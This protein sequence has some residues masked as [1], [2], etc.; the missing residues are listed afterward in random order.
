M[1]LRP[2]I[3]TIK[4]MATVDKRCTLE[5][6]AGRTS[7]RIFGSDDAARADHVSHDCLPR[8]KALPVP[9]TGDHGAV[10]WL[11]AQICCAHYGG[12]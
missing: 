12:Q 5:R 6:D 3:E 8:L 7:R 10:K 2:G 4:T 11:L 1:G 9:G